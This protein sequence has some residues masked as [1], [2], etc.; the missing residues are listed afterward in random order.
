MSRRQFFRPLHPVVRRFRPV[1]ALIVLAGVLSGGLAAYYSGSAGGYVVQPGDSLW[2]IALAHGTTV[3][4]LASVNHLDPNGLLIIGRHLEL[5]SGEG[6]YL[7]SSAQST[8][9]ASSGAEAQAFCAGLGP[10]AGPYGVLP[11]ALASSPYRLDLQPLFRQW[12]TYYG[13]YLPL[14]EA[15]DWQES[16]WQQSVVSYTGAVGVGQ[17]M[18]ATGQ[19]ITNV[20]VGQPM[21]VYSVSDNIRMSAAFLAYLSRV[22]HGNQCATIAAYYEGPLNLATVGVFSS[23]RQY[24]AD[25]EGLLPRFE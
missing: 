10:A 15:V 6:A 9:A 22:E 20:L 21:N 11:P 23:T 5:P 3:A 8:N 16:G 1:A 14:L 25:V 7:A 12:A 17:I 18:P 24:V 19:F 4:E 2:S 13:L